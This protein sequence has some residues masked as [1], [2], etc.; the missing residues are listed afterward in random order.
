MR[1]LVASIARPARLDFGVQPLPRPRKKLPRI[2]RPDCT[3]TEPSCLEKTRS[4]V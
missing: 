1:C 3:S 2:W 4:Y